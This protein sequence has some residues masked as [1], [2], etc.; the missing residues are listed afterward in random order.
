V[1]VWHDSWLYK[2]WVVGG[3]IAVVAF[4]VIG[5]TSDPGNQD[6]VFTLIP[7]IAVWVFGIFF[8]QWR[9]LQKDLKEEP[10]TTQPIA[11]LLRWNIIFGAVLC[12]AIFVG[13]YLFYKDPD[14][15][16]HPLGEGGPGLPVFLIPAVVLVVYGALRTLHVLREMSRGGGG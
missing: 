15:T 12:V 4:A 13:V 2:L 14:N 11:G 7:V 6:F 9:G 3:L 16:F 10:K 1:N 8:L 5:G